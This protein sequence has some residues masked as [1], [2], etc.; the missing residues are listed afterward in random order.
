M[1]FANNLKA[2]RKKRG[3]TQSSL[4]ELSELKQ[5]TI[6]CYESGIRKPSLDKLESII[7]ALQCEYADLL[8]TPP[9]ILKE[10]S[11]SVKANSRTG[12]LIE[13]FE[14][15]PASQ[16]RMILKQVQAITESE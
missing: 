2:I 13:A 6:A 11:T 5:E 16:Q 7:S 14:S 1:N 12:K 9:E 10:S 8:G 15:L 4:A 3:L